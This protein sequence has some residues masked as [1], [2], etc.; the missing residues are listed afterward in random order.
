MGC[1]ADET[2]RDYQEMI[3][4]FKACFQEMLCHLPVMPPAVSTHHRAVIDREG[5]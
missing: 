3:T 2:G 5:K 1:G 4:A